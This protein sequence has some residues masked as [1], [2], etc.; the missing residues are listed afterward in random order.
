MKRVFVALIFCH[1]FLFAQTPSSAISP[2]FIQDKFDGKNKSGIVVGLGLGLPSLSTQYLSGHTF[3]NITSYGYHFLVGYQDFTRL[4]SPFP[5]NIFGARISFEFDDTFHI[6]ERTINSSNLLI[7]YDLLID[8]FARK[9]NP[10]GFIIGIN[11]GLTQIKS[12]QS[13]SFSI[14]AKL[15]LSL[16]FTTD[17]RL[18]ITYKVASSGP[19]QG[20]S[21]YFY[22]PYT[23]D[24]TYTYR[25]SIPFK[26]QE[27]VKENPFDNTKYLLK[28]KPQ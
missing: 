27:T 28:T 7:N 23:I 25:F 21:L 10:I 22:S 20:N 1:Y 5:P 2:T 8:A 11:L 12:Y 14:G 6:G 13:F 24:L 16:A 4:L 19:L 9:K 26:R 17:H 18:D 3:S 15:G